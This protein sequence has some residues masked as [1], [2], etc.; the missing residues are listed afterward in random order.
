M[1]KC[2]LLCTDSS[3]YVLLCT[4]SDNAEQ[5]VA[6][7]KTKHYGAPCRQCNRRLAIPREHQKEH[8]FLR[9]LSR[10][11][12][13]R[14]KL[15]STDPAPLSKTAAHL[16][17]S[18]GEEG[19]EEEYPDVPGTVDPMRG[20]VSLDQLFAQAACLHP[21]LC[22]KIRSWALASNGLFP[23]MERQF[24]PQSVMSS[25]GESSP[26]VKFAK[27]KSVS[28]AIEKVGTLLFSYSC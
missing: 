21:V 4:E 14:R 27:I 8:G 5:V 18:G 1:S 17:A 25:S 16:F 19:G 22:E 11:V 6:F 24:V 9:Y 28:R 20:V 23:N 15:S 10:R 26:V 3:K 13:G 2:V 7:A 12:A